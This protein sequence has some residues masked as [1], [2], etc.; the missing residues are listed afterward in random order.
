M[1]RIEKQNF[2]ENF[3]GSLSETKVL[4]VSHYKGLSVSEISELRNKTKHEKATFKVTK[5]SLAKIAIKDT[6]YKNLSRFFNGPT[7]VT[8]S[9]DPASAAKVIFNFAK[10]NENLKIIGG[11]IEDKELSIDEI[12]TLAS[13]PSLDELRGKIVG[14]ISSPLRNIA[15]ILNQPASSIT[16]I[17]NKKNKDN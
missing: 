5:N 16:R 13:L 6:C 12:K 8:F 3:R 2:V 14:L 11:A 17:I 9:D 1:N 4:L 15:T 7:A 10:E